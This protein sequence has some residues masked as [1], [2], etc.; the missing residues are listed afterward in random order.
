MPRLGKSKKPVVRVNSN[1]NRTPAPGRRN[2]TEEAW[3][4]E[5]ALD[6]YYDRFGYPVR[7]NKKI[8]SQKNLK[9]KNKTK[10]EKK[11][12]KAANKP[13]RGGGLRGGIGSG[14]FGP[15]VR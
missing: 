4:R 13:R 7:E 3:G 14:P 15:R 1:P 11:A 12:L 9:K 6:P 5:E 8:N 10:T 2:P